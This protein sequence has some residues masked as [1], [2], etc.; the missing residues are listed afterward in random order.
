MSSQHRPVGDAIQK[1]F[2]GIDPNQ[3]HYLL[4]P[5]LSVLDALVDAVTATDTSIPPLRILAR[6]DTLYETRQRFSLASRLQELIDDGRVTVRK[7]PV[8]QNTTALVSETGLTT[9]VV[10]A[11]LV[12]WLQTDEPGDPAGLFAELDELWD[13]SERYSLLTPPLAPTLDAARERL[14]E[15]FA[16]RFARAVEWG[17]N[18]PDPTEFHATRA[19]VVIGA[20]G[21]QLHFDVSKWGEDT[22]VAS[23]ATF[24]RQK[25]DLEERGLVRTEK[26]AVDMGRPRQRLFLTEKYRDL[27]DEEGLDGLLATAVA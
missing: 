22:G 13:E 5:P 17:E 24:S 4:N 19:A 9:F 1:V 6:N 20:A 18:R 11:D 23:K 7:S 21:E 8:E 2:T 26:V 27:L 15:T 16:D 10:I 25:G 3:R 12:E 14:G